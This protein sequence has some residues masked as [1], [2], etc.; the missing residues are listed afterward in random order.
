MEFFSPS[1][2]SFIEP[3]DL[4]ERTLQL[5][6]VKIEDLKLSETVIFSFIPEITKS[7]IKKLGMLEAES[8]P[9]LRE[10]FYNPSSPLYPFSVFGS[11]VGA[12]YAIM[13]MEQLIVLGAKRFYFIGFC[14]GIGKDVKIGD[15]IIPTEAIREE[16]T[17][18]HYFPG[19]VKAEANGRMTEQVL[20]ITDQ[21][22]RKAIPGLLWTTDA[23][24]RETREKVE[25]YRQMG[26][27]GVDME[28][29]AVYALS[30]YRN[31]EAVA[32]HVVSDIVGGDKWQTSF[33]WKELIDASKLACNILIKACQEIA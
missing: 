29:S 25:R 18:Y 28:T 6:K 10:K 27:L 8:F 24:Y 30:R 3:R 7:L 4:L 17:S 23:L 1:R 33:G 32:L 9:V 14:G 22:E 19:H 13:L 16:G 31:V 21:L 11:P 26:V 20:K 5:R 15:L 2:D 12:P